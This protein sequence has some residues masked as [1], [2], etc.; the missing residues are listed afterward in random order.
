MALDIESVTIKRPLCG[1]L[2]CAPN[3]ADGSGSAVRPPV[4]TGK[5]AAHSGRPRANGG[6][7][8][9]VAGAEDADRPLA[10]TRE[11]RLCG[12]LSKEVL[13]HEIRR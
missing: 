11:W 12:S 1:A 5:Y 6:S 9:Q 10:V 13:S 8:D 7:P 4:S 3:V 2:I